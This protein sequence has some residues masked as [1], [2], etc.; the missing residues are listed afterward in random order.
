MNVSSIGCLLE[1]LKALNLWKYPI[2]H[3]FKDFSQSVLQ[4]PFFFC[5]DTVLY[6]PDSSPTLTDVHLQDCWLNKV[7]KYVCPHLQWWKEE[8]PSKIRVV[9]KGQVLKPE[10]SFRFK[11]L[12]RV[13]IRLPWS[14]TGEDGSVEQAEGQWT[15]SAHRQDDGVQGGQDVA[16][17]V[18]WLQ[19]LRQL[20]KWSHI[21]H[22]RTATCMDRDMI[23]R[24]QV[25]KRH[26]SWFI[27]VTLCG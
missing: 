11:V 17:C 9:S 26:S 15:G 19:G 25:S 5:S 13:R 23:G 12:K 7:Y 3:F 22:R 24:K 27:K 18:V 4:C 21:L 10:L 8:K 14:G 2:F 20:G 16:L 1:T 6:A